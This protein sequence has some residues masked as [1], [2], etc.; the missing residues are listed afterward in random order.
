MSR[1]KALIERWN[2]HQRLQHVLLLISVSGLVLTGFPIKY[3]TQSWAKTAT[4]M[5]GG[6]ERLFGIHLSMA[7]LLFLTSGYHLLYLLAYWRKVGPSWAMVPGW[8]DLRDGWHH[9][10]HLIGIR[11]RP[12]HFGRYTYLE[13][14]EYLAVVWGMVFMGGSG[15]ILWFPVK[16]AALLPAWG[17][18]TVRV[19]HSNEAFIA[20]LALAFGHFFSVHF[21]PAVF[22]NNEVWLTGRISLAR[23]AE[24]H[25][26]ELEHLV[27]AGKISAA[28]AEAATSHHEPHRPFLLWLELAAYAGVFVWLLITFVPMLFA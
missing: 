7:V 1:N 10:L 28:E 13:K 2:V 3:Y 5:V 15:L 12:P 24:E 22:P 9:A 23:L 19:I 11:R 4:L 21:H 17:L 18:E 14:F 25:P 27:A 26:A 8:R 20:M 6:F 16:A